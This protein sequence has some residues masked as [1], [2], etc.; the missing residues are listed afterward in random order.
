MDIGK[1]VIIDLSSY[2]KHKGAVAKFNFA[3]APFIDVSKW[4]NCKLNVASDTAGYLRNEYLLKEMSL[5]MP[6]E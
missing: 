3:T 1:D 2:R 5:A 4:V 6:M